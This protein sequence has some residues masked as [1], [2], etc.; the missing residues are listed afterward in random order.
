[1][2]P[3]FGLLTFFS[4]VAMTYSQKLQ[5]LKTQNPAFDFSGGAFTL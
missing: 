4:V 2:N 1:M 5:N 3:A